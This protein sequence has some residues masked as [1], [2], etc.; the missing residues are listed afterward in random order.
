M[1]M[2][3]IVI[4]KPGE[5]SVKEVPNPMPGPGEVIIKVKTCGVCAT[6]YHIFLGEFPANYPLIPGHEISGE[7]TELGNGVEELKI[8]SRVAVDPSIYCGNCYFCKTNRGNHCYDFR[9]LGV[10]Q[11]GGF[12]ESMAATSAC[13]SSVV[14]SNQVAICRRG[15]SSACPGVLRRTFCLQAGSPVQL[16]EGRKNAIPIR[17][18]GFTVARETRE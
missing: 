8:G 15:M 5:V 9:A 17:H 14:A 3:A 7:I 6:D 2:K 11:N 4:E 16:Y 12:A 10:T 18:P 13:C 1:I